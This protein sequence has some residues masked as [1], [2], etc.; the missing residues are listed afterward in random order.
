M[1][2][3]KRLAEIREAFER[4]DAAEPAYDSVRDL[5]IMLDEERMSAD[6]L[7]VRQAKRTADALAKTEAALRTCE[8]FDRIA[9]EQRER[10]RGG[11]A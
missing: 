9:Q 3:E 1:K 7:I 10:C 4:L 5:L 6:D 2:D 11:R 8:K